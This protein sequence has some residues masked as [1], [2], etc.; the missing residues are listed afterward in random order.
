MKVRFFERNDA[1]RVLSWIT[2]EREFRFWSAD[3]YGDYPIK[4]D[5]IL[6]YYQNK[7]S[8]EEFYPLTFEEKGEAIGHMI[9]RYPTR[10]KKLARLGFIIVDNKKRGQ[11]YGRQVV[12]EGIKYA[13][14][15]LVAIKYNLGVFT[16]NVKAIKC[17]E[18]IGFK[19]LSVK[20]KLYKFYN[21][22]WDMQEMLYD[23]ALDIF[24]MV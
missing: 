18:S 3:Q 20:K 8:Q 2:S 22:E 9:L 4:P 21:E 24:S 13:S 7:I 6:T 5:D 19:T 14:Q 10:D 1:E 17:Y 12:Y 15:H 11:G 16:N 23:P